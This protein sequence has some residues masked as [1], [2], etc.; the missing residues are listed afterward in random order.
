MTANIAGDLFASAKARSGSEA[1]WFDGGESSWTYDRLLA[2]ASAVAGW[3]HDRGVVAGDR[4][5]VV[6]G[7]WPEHVA[8]WYG[9]LG[10]GAVVVD[11]NYIL[12]DEEWW[13][14]LDDCAPAAVVAGAPFAGRIRAMSREL[15]DVPVLVADA[16]GAS[17]PA[18]ALAGVPDMEPQPRTDD[19]LAVICYTSG[20]T[21]LPKGVMH[22]HGLIGE[23]LRLLADVQDYRVGDVVYQAVPLFAIQGFLPT[24]ASMIRAGGSVVLAERF[25]PNDLARVSRRLGI[26][27]IT[28]SAPMLEAITSLPDGAAEFPNLRLLTAGGAPLQPEARARFEERVG[29][30]VSQGYGMTEVMGVMVVDYAGDAPCGSCGRVWPEGSRDIV[31]LG[32]DDAPLEAGHVG[33]FAVHRRRALAGYWRRPDLWAECFT[34]DWFRTGDI[35][36]IDSDGYFYVLDRKKDMIIRGGFNIY[37]AE[38]ERVLSAHPDVA[39]ATVVGAPDERLGE[40]PVAFV[41]PRAPV[42]EASQLAD[43]LLRQCRARLGS[44]K[45]PQWIR[46]VDFDALPRTA[47]RKVL[48]RAL[49]ASLGAPK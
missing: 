29:V 44:L 34:G 43:Q 16:C 40:V 22:T 38:I 4:V 31:V 48:K 19:D 7:S 1:L 27:Y 20:T 39:E 47:L 10:V 45:T 13:F 11:V 35:G 5:A 3:L 33:E 24:V 49:R 26:T 21:G 2:G 37:S 12:Q 42:A 36:R 17:W 28:L 18:D 9:I 8:A 14:V 6:M 46:V 23:Q 41:V 15:G 32:E 30:P 25:D